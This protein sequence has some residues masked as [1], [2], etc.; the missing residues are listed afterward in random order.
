MNRKKV[1]NE[2]YD[3]T[4]ITLGAVGVGM[5]TRK[6]FSDGL[7]TPASLAS[8]LK[9]AAAVGLSTLGFKFAQ[10]KKWLPTDPFKS[11]NK[12]KWKK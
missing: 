5:I 9:L 8:T 3:S 10:D 7:A 6:T 1:V 4:L 12:N 11:L 2:L